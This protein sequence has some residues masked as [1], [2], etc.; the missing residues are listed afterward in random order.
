MEKFDAVIDQVVRN[1]N[2]TVRTERAEY[3]TLVVVFDGEVK[4]VNTIISGNANPLTD[5]EMIVLNQINSMLNTE[6]RD[7][8]PECGQVSGLKGAP[9]ERLRVRVTRNPSFAGKGRG[10][11]LFQRTLDGLMA[12]KKIDAMD[13]WVWVPL[14][15]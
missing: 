9:I 2:G 7:L 8:P 3:P 14:I 5:K 1:E 6:G 13:D 11:A 15:D 12:K 10:V 4:P